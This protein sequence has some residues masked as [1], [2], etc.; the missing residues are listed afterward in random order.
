[1]PKSYMTD[2]DREGLSQNGIY[3]SECLA[4]HEA[5]DED[6]SWEWLALAELP[7]YSLMSCKVNLGAD[8]IR[9]KGLNT[10][11]ADREYGPGWLDAP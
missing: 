6:A 9:Q 7:A 2:A 4:A 1:M 8:F 5:G 11:P 10:Q 3:L